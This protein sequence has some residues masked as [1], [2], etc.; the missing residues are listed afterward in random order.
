MVLT[1]LALL[2]N[3]INGL[4]FHNISHMLILQPYLAGR[5]VVGAGLLY[6]RN[7]WHVG[8]AFYNKDSQ[9][10][11]DGENPPRAGFRFLV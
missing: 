7:G 9:H 6:D 5:A 1:Q 4:P 2:M 10:I 3:S 11:R 8:L